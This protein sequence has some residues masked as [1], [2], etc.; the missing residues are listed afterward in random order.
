[1]HEGSGLESSSKYLQY[2]IRVFLGLIFGVVSHP[3]FLLP[4]AFLLLSSQVQAYLRD[5]GHSGVVGLIVKALQHC[6]NGM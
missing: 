3:D 6:D 4:S 2:V 1:M 5:A